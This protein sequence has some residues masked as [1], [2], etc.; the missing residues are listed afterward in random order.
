MPAPDSARLTH[1]QLLDH[2][3]ER[4]CPRGWSAIL[5]YGAAVNRLAADK[6]WD[7]CKQKV[8]ALLSE[9]VNNDDHRDCDFRMAAELVEALEREDE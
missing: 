5:E 1:P 9:W 2:I 8:L 7:A 4:P 3:F 6:A